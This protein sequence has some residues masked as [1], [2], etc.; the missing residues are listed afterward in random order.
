MRAMATKSDREIASNE[1]MLSTKS[2]N[3]VDYVDASTHMTNKKDHIPI[4]P[5]PV[6]T[7]LDRMVV[8]DKELH[9][10]KSHVFSIT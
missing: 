2:K 7:Q 9:S 8:C 6:T 3:S 4:S 5:R 1:R 10:T